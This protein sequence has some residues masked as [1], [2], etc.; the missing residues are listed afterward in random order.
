VLAYHANG[1][2]GGGALTGGTGTVVQTYLTDEFG[3]PTVVQGGV[4]MSQPFLFTGE[5]Y[6]D[7]TNLLHLRARFYDPGMGR[8]LTRDPVSGA[9]AA[10]PTLNR[11]VYAGNNPASLA[12]PS[13]FSGWFPR[14]PSPVEEWLNNKV[15]TDPLSSLFCFLF[16][17]RPQ[18]GPGGTLSLGLDPLG[19]KPMEFGGDDAV[20]G[21]GAAAQRRWSSRRVREAAQDLEAGATQA[22]VRTR[23]EAEELL[24]GVYHGHGY[25]NTTGLPGEFIDSQFGSKAGT[26]QW[27]DIVS[28]EGILDKHASQNPHSTMRHLEVWTNEGSIVRIFWGDTLTHM[29]P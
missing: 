17:V 7:E 4:G 1:R 5:P 23:E 3:V 6:D 22:Y 10:P 15:C 27:H 21:G 29:G 25:R 19:N 13:G 14:P 8:F 9:L 28:P 12:D 26:Y 16:G 18:P 2:G 11:F 24:L 20:S